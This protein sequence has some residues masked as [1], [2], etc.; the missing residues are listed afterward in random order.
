MPLLFCDALLES[1]L[2]G[3]MVIPAPFSP[4]SS[5]QKK[6]RRG[7][8]KASEKAPRSFPASEHLTETDHAA[9][10]ATSASAPLTTH[11]IQSIAPAFGLAKLRIIIFPAAPS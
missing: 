9:P 5:Q 10:P 8:A 11:Q 2:G 3:E 4:F 7:E 6:G 1:V